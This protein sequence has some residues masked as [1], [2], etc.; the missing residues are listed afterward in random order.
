MEALGET[1]LVNQFTDSPIDYM[2][3]YPDRWAQSFAYNQANKLVPAQVK[4]LT[5][6]GSRAAGATLDTTWAGKTLDRKFHRNYG[7]DGERLTTNDL[8][9]VLTNRLKKYPQ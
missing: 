7:L 6:A 9:N 8:L 1:P 4:S 5:R 3:K 2:S